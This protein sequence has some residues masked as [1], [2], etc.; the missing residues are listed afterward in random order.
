M[1]LY[2]VQL[3]LSFV[4]IQSI[5]RRSMPAWPLYRLDSVLTIYIL[6]WIHHVHGFS[7]SN[8]AYTL[9]AAWSWNFSLLLCMAT[10]FTSLL[11]TW[12]V[13]QQA[14]YIYNAVPSVLVSDFL[15]TTALLYYAYT[16]QLSVLF[17]VSFNTACCWMATVCYETR[18]ETYFQFAFTNEH[19]SCTHNSI[20]ACNCHSSVMV[21]VHA[22]VVLLV[23]PK[24][25][26]I[27]HI[28]IADDSQSQTSKIK[29][30]KLFLANR[31]SQ[32]LNTKG[33][34]IP[35]CIIWIQHSSCN[36]F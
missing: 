18:T 30:K 36:Y 12:Q 7:T 24:V 32:L 4:K 5:W 25:R 21:H 8:T 9:V 20:A 16:M 29:K 13:S 6:G 23:M 2:I 22:F 10:P 14:L 15:V 3:F 26:M 17:I 31:T 35:R 34:Y 19:S 1:P 27:A 11:T 28:V 33:L